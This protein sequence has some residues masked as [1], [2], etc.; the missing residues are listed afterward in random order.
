MI[1]GVQNLE[2]TEKLADEDFTFEKQQEHLLMS[3]LAAHSKLPVKPQ[4]AFLQKKL[5]QQ[6]KFFDS[7]DYAMN[8]QKTNNPSV[9]LSN[10]NLQNVAHRSNSLSSAMQEVDTPLKIDVSPTIRDESLLIP[11]PDTVPQ[12]KSS[13]IYPSVHSKLSPQPYIHHSTHDSDLLPG[14]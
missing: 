5:Q 7:G 13:I 2:Q 8:K 11:R 9:N 6:R 14:P 1:G 4:S 3:K 10:A 12:R